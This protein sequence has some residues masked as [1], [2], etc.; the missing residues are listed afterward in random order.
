V[1]RAGGGHVVEVYPA[2]ALSRWQLPHKGYKGAGKQTTL[3][4]LVDE[5]LSALPGLRLGDAEAICR[6]SDDA[7]DSVVCAL[8]ARAASLGLVEPVPAERAA[9][10]SS[11]GWIALPTSPLVELVR[12]N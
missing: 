8:V 11:E 2:A 10:A 6:R 5:L 3:G 7:L 9:R 1:D 12:P 4:R